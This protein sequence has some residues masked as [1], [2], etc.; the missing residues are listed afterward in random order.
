VEQV[1]ENGLVLLQPFQGKVRRVFITSEE[2]RGSF[3]EVVE[4]PAVLFEEYDARSEAIRPL[5]Y[6]PQSE[7]ENGTLSVTGPQYTDEHGYSYITYDNTRKTLLLHPR[8]GQT[9]RLGA[10]TTLRIPESGSYKVV[11][12]FALANKLKGLG[13]GVR[14][15]IFIGDRP[16]KLLFD[17]LITSQNQVDERDFFSGPGVAQFDLHITLKQDDELH[18]AVLS[19]SQL[20]ESTYDLAAL[21]FRVSNGHTSISMPENFPKRP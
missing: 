13:N 12:A 6:N 19:G 14:V 9:S 15:V 7:T 20:A 4:T 8:T 3:E 5:L 1:T 10:V 16:T 17:S 11:G 2:L 18:F 21:R